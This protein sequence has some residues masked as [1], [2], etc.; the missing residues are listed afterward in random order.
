MCCWISGSIDTPRDIV[1]LL[2]M[3]T[4]TIHLA[5]WKFIHSLV[6]QGGGVTHGTWAAFTKCIFQSWQQLSWRFVIVIQVGVARSNICHIFYLRQCPLATFRGSSECIICYNRQESSSPPVH[7]PWLIAHR[8]PHLV[9]NIQCHVL[10]RHHAIVSWTIHTAILHV[11]NPF[12]PS[13]I[14]AATLPFHISFGCCHKIEI[15]L[16]LLHIEI[17]NGC[18]NNNEQLS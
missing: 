8:A 4:N 10:W 7:W 16:L 1:N 15:W 3:S 11:S 5:W 2:H 18:I 9:H 6:D 14:C 13:T 17:T 12:S